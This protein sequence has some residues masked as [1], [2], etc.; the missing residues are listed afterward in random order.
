MTLLPSRCYRGGCWKNAGALRRYFLWSSSLP[1]VSFPT[2]RVEIPTTTFGPGIAQF[3]Q[4]E[5]IL[6]T[7]CDGIGFY[8]QLTVEFS[9]IFQTIPQHSRNRKCIFIPVFFCS[10]SLVTSCLLG[11]T[12]SF[13]FVGFDLCYV[14]I[15][16]VVLV[17]RWLR[18]YFVGYIGVR[19]LLHSLVILLFW[20]YYFTLPPH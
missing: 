4:P 8:N 2:Q 1:I 15:T 11:V 12:G 20:I 3:C 18:W 16:L 14:G 9:R 6:S 19:Y 10:F 7:F 13:Y 17:L 5:A